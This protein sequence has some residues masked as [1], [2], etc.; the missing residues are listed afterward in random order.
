MNRFISILVFLFAISGIYAQDYNSVFYSDKKINPADTGKIFLRIENVNFLKN[1]EYFNHTVAGHTDFGYFL[2]PSAVYTPFP[3]LKIE[4]GIHLLKYSG[5]SN[6]SQTEP[7]FRAHYSDLKGFNLIMG[8]LY[9]TV[10]HNLIEP[11]FR[12]EHFFE[13]NTENGLQVIFDKKYFY[14]DSW[15][16]WERFIFQDDPYQERIFLGTNSKLLLINKDKFK[17]HIP[18]QSVIFHEGGQIDV[19]SDPVTAYTNT[20]SGV[21]FTYMPTGN[22]RK[23]ITFNS[24]YLTYYDISE[25]KIKKY[26]TGYG[27]YSSVLGKL[28]NWQAF[29]GFWH[30][31]TFIAP[32]GEPYLQSVSQIYGSYSEP[33]KDILLIKF[34]YDN[35]IYN[36]VTLGFRLET[37]YEFLHK[38]MDYAYGVHLIFNRDF[39]LGKVK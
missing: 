11:L 10:N 12:F 29:C 5:L 9:G 35:N 13:R 24:W 8:S 28:N 30:G 27:I 4:A 39:F 25:M 36:G 33:E 38:E 16:C 1:N 2:R 31:A 22:D 21:S 32:K 34:M 6:F 18:F 19:S 26:D 37:Y 23:K 20:A 3:R 17:L 7:I 14:S 15:L